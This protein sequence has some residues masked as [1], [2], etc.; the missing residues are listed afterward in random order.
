M[1]TNTTPSQAE[2]KLELLLAALIPILSETGIGG[3]FV[4]VTLWERSR[5][6]GKKLP[7]EKIA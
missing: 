4:V 2:Q 5:L 6:Q 7:N 1:V 3:S